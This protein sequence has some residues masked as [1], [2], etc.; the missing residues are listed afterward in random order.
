MSS[1]TASRTVASQLVSQP[2][3]AVRFGDRAW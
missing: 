1:G 2:G 3:V